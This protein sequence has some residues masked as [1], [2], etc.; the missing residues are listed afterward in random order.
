[1]KRHTPRIAGLVLMLVILGSVAQ[2]VNVDLQVDPAGKVPRKSALVTSGIP[3]EKGALK[4]VSKLSASVDGKPVPAQFAKTVRWDDGSVRW[5]L[6]DTQIAMPP[7]GAAKLVVSDSGKNPRPASPVKVEDGAEA[8]KVSTGPLV[9]VLGKKKPGLIESLKV[10]GKELLT[11]TGKGLVIVKEGGGEVVASAPSEVRVEHAGP[12][13]AVVCLKGSFPGLHKGLLRYTARISVHAGQKFIKVHLWLENHGADGHGDVKPEW[14]AFDGMAVDLGLG[15]GE[16]LVASC[17]GV[18]GKGQLKVLQVCKKGAKRPKSEPYYTNKELE[19]TIHSGAEELKKGQRT[20]G[21]VQIKGDAG[22]LTAGI[23]DFW[24]NY[25][26]AIEVNGKTLRLWLWPTEGKWPRPGRNL[27]SKHL[28]RLNGFAKDKLYLLRGS[29]HKG[30]EFILDFSGRATEATAAELSEPFFARAS[31]QYYAQTEAVPAIFTPGTAKTGNRG[32]DFKLKSW[33]KMGRNVADPKTTKSIF[34]ARNEYQ[35]FGIGY[36]GDSS[37]WYGW[38]DFG[39]L[40]VPGKGQVSLHYDWPL[41]V[42]LEY[43]RNG[44]ASALRLATEMARHRIDV[45]QYWSDRDPPNINGIQSGSVWP[46]F[47]AKGGKRKGRA[48]G[49]NPGGTWIAG[50][51]LWYMLTGEPKAREACLRSAEGLVRAWES[52]AKE[53]VYGGGIKV[54]MAA[55]AWAIDSFCATYDL[56]GEKRWLNEA[57]KLFNTNI[58]DKWKKYGPHLHAPGKGQL[59]GQS[60]IKEDIQYCYAIAQLCNLHR[61]TGDK[62][63]LK[64]LTDGCEKPLSPDSYFDAPIFTAGLYAYVGRVTQNPVYLKKAVEDFGL[65]F[66]E[67]K[68]PPVYLPNNNTW[69]SRAA[70]LLRAGELVQYGLGK[71]GQ[72]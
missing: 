63:V 29:A 12:V 45:D 59:V 67:S 39:D 15:L 48:T 17:E 56:T 37:H 34:A 23:R 54:R 3:F 38:M 52:I 40:S 28:R 62:N 72:K 60:Y 66:P 21:I 26:K 53:K 24:Q 5:A 18:K 49:P 10:D 4:D 2:A 69:S 70:M 25:E 51:A 20:D 1:M 61:Q 11:A 13:R 35:V 7:A 57:L 8:V 50:P 32:C 27:T 64:L 30:H 14:F 55:N 31:A 65:G 41:L 36:F 42:M 22:V 6:L 33:N 19:Y 44:D 47:H 46:T 58:T 68:N 16:T 9:L 43:L 71:Q